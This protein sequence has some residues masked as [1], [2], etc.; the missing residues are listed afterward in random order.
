MARAPGEAGATPAARAESVGSRA[1]ARALLF[2][3]GVLFGLLAV[4]ARVATRLGLTSGQVATVRFSVATVLMLGMFRAWPGTFRPYDRRLLAARGILGGLAALLYFIALSLVPAGQATLLNNTFPV[5]AVAISYF[6][7]GERPGWQ[8][9]LALLV[10]SAGVFLVLGGGGPGTP[11]GWGHVAAIASA[12]FAGGAVTSIRALRAF[13]N[14]PTIFFAFSLGGLAVSA[15]F[16][17]GPWTMAP[18]A[19]L[20]ALLG[21]LVALAAQL[22]MTEAYGALTVAEAA[23]WQQLTPV[24]SYLWA[25]SLLGERL[26]AVG[27][28]GVLLGA[29]GVVYAS[30][31]GRRPPEAEEA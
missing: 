14:A 25:M 17:L 6:A 27:A 23:V 10:T 11:F 8:L 30:I 24:A 13:H 9:V 15:P 21:A 7:L 12:L 1:R 19:W 29:A 20:A 31:Q 28:A 16:A 4:L 26:S 5:V 18:A 22:L 2:A 3:S